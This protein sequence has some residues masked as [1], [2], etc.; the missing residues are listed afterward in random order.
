MSL[1]HVTYALRVGC[2]GLPV[3][4]YVVTR[5][6][7]LGLQRQY[8]E[9]IAHVYET[10]II[11]RESDGQFREVVAPLTTARAQCHVSRCPP[12]GGPHQCAAT[13]AEEP[14]GAARAFV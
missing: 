3:I 9:R 11:V 4:A 6:V 1:N 2:I 7:C 12:R 10:G 13:A 8:D 5:R 14:E